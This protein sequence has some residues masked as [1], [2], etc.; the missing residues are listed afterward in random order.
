M[1]TNRKEACICNGMR[2][3]TP[4]N[5]FKYFGILWQC[6]TVPQ[7][8]PKQYPQSWHPEGNQ[9]YRHNCP[10]GWNDFRTGNYSKQPD[11]LLRSSLLWRNGCLLSALCLCSG[12][13]RYP[14]Q[15]LS[16]YHTYTSGWPDRCGIS[17]C[18]WLVHCPSVLLSA[19]CDITAL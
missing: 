12:S 11:L 8:S 16:F 1:W 6:E 19:L 10:T 13:Q 18:M 4:L 9:R 15:E 17:L 7:V 5:A 14:S 2:T 3:H